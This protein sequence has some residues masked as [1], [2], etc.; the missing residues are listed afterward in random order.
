MRKHGIN[1]D[2][3]RPKFRVG[4][5]VIVDCLYSNLHGNYT[6]IKEILRPKDDSGY[7]KYLCEGG[8]GAGVWAEEFL[9]D[10]GRKDLP[11]IPEQ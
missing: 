2:K 4:Q 10:T 7:M 1:F 6:V 5:V 8:R 9:A 11:A 3:P